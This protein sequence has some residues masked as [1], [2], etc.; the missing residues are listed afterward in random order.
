M[1]CFFK[2]LYLTFTTSQSQPISQPVKSV[3]QSTMSAK[4]PIPHSRFHLPL[5]YAPYM[6]K[7]D[8]CR[9]CYNESLFKGIISKICK[10]CFNNVNDDLP[11]LDDG[12]SDINAAINADDDDDDDDDDYDDDDVEIY[13]KPST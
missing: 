6:V 9:S 12:S 7:D 8:I 5:R 11:M 1:K 3:N 4:D 2:L 10:F 13:L